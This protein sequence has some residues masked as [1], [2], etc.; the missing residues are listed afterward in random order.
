MRT[1]HFSS[2]GRYPVLRAFA[3]LYVL[4]AVIAVISGIGGALW[5]LVA[6]PWNVGN[7]VALALLA[8]AGT[9]FL[10]VGI[11]AVAE[12]IKLF[13]DIEHNTRIHAHSLE[14]G[15]VQTSSSQGQRPNR[16]RELDEETAEGALLRGH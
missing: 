6:A 5:A 1:P 15:M 2:G 10:V 11:L 9:F 14:E 8:L 7:R 4:M 16:L 3:I 12:V 13:I